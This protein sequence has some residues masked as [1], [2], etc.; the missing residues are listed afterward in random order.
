MLRRSLAIAAVAVLWAGASSALAQTN[1]VADVAGYQGADR[2]QRLL[3]GAKREKE[4]TLYS[5]IPPADIAALAAAFD[6]KYGIKVKVWRSDSEGFLQRVLNE[7]RARRFDVDIMAGA[8]SAIGPL[9]REK[10]RQG[11]TSPYLVDR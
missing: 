6:K 2:Q 1:P 9:Y 11:V 8:S 7:A 5:S 4:L 10:L 3:E